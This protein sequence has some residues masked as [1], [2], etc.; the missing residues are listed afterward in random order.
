MIANIAP[1]VKLAMILL[2][3]L[4]GHPGLQALDTVQNQTGYTHA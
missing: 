1:T 3:R 2:Q 4:Q